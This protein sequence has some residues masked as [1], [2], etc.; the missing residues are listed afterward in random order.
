MGADLTIFN[1]SD[2][3][4]GLSEADAPSQA[5]IALTLKLENCS[6]RRLIGQANTM[7]LYKITFPCDRDGLSIHMLNANLADGYGV[8]EEFDEIVSR[9]QEQLV[10]THYAELPSDQI[11]QVFLSWIGTKA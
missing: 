4:P 1:F 3:G 11:G 8:K 10:G 2:I 7:A 9:L 5:G 6:V